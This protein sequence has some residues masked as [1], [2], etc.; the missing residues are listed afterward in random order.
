MDDKSLE[1][2]E[3]HRVREILA[4][5]TFFSASHDLASNLQP[6]TDVEQISLLLRQSAEARH[7]LSL[8]P[9]FSIGDIVDVREVVMMAARGKLLEPPILIEIHKTLAATRQLHSNLVKLSTELP[10]LCNIVNGIVELRQL[11]RDIGNCLAPTGEVLDSASPRLASIRQQLR[12]A[13]ENLLRHLETTMRAPRGRRIIQEHIVTEREGRYVIPIKSE[14][15]KE[16]KGIVHDVSNTGATVF[17][18]PW[19]TVELGN[20]LR[21]LL[22][23]EKHEIER[24]LSDLSTRAGAHEVEISGNIALAAELDLALAKAR[25]ARRARATEPVL[26]TFAEN[27]GKTTGAQAGVLKLVAARHPLLGEKAVPLSV[28][29][30]RDF[31]ILVITGPNT[32]GKT[33]ALK[34]I[35]LLSLMTQAGLPIPASAESCIPIFDNVFADIGDEQSIEQTLSTFSWHISNLVRIINQATERSLVLIDELGTSTDP[36]EGSAL[37]R[38]IMLHLL[39]RRTLSVATT[40]YGDLKA[41]A[42]TTAGFQNASLDFDPVTLTPTYHLTVGLPG[43]SNALATAAR[44]GL[45]SEIVTNAREMLSE[46]TEQLET[47]LTDLA[48]EKQRFDALHHELENERREAAQRKSELENELQ[49][50]RTEERKSIQEARD[51]LVHEAAEL[52]KE[53]R[54][55][56]AELRKEKTRERI[57][58]ARRMMASMQEQLQSEAWQPRTGTAGEATD[59]SRITV[60]DTVWLKDADL[61][62]TV[63]SISEDTQQIEVQARQTRFRLSLDSVTKITAPPS[64]EKPGLTRVTRK[65]MSR[66]VLP[67]FHL[68]GRRA[69]E[70]EPMLDSYLNDACLANLNEVRI[71]HGVGTGTVRQIVRDLLATHPLV[72]SFRPGGPGEGGNGATVVQL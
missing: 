53:I 61:P 35:G 18:E 41:F 7:L 37:A 4:G 59:E 48:G 71:V 32:G 13:R 29:I 34:T 31:A 66:S 38:S 19:A 33:V 63:L 54:Q 23:A 55:A 26:T 27:E 28:E 11:E 6:L 25:Y 57:E 2:L 21:E 45:P 72:K 46:G 39:S 67:E 43:G 16:I 10:L 49:R 68:L 69:D 42:H 3:F 40:H 64:R 47:L 58:Q 9:S 8:E 50:L 56:T 70:V 12:H 62:A 51:K 1:L 24:I 5:Y 22:M 15:R 20:E 36:A 65:P 14:F 30:G 60:G 52:Q 44:L 17:V